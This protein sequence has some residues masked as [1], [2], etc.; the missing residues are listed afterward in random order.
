MSDVVRNNLATGLLVSQLPKFGNLRTQADVEKFVG[1]KGLPGKAVQ[2]ITSAARAGNMQ[3]ALEYASMLAMENPNRLGELA[4][5]AIAGMG[6]PGYAAP[7]V[8]AQ[9]M[10]ISRS[11]ALAN[12]MA[13]GGGAVGAAGLTGGAG[14]DD[15]IGAGGYANALKARGVPAALI[16]QFIAAGKRNNVSPVLLA[17][18]EIERLQADQ[19]RQ[20]AARTADKVRPRIRHHADHVRQHD[21]RRVF[22]IRQYRAR[23]GDFRR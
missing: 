10:N 11:D 5:P 17:A 23:R 21:P 16:P 15:R 22:N 12:A 4:A 19:R 18:I 1:R 3:I 8:S 14:F 2:L 13:G 20:A 9:L 6:I 7:L